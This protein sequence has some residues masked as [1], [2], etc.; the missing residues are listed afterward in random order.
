MQEFGAAKAGPVFLSEVQ[1]TGSEENLT[2][3][4]HVDVNNH[5]CD[6]GAGVTCGNST[7]SK[8]IVCTFSLLY[9]DR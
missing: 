7:R 9:H 4:R 8:C 5:K 1:C 2:M 6:S 3:C